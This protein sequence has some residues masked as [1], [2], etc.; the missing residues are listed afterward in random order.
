METMRKSYETRGL[1]G[2]TNTNYPL[3]NPL[4][5]IRERMALWFLR[6]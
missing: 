1:Y 3:P 5:E 4:M 6:L 2:G